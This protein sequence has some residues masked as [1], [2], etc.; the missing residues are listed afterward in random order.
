MQGIRGIELER[1]RGEQQDQ[2]TATYVERLLE[3]LESDPHLLDN[4]FDKLPAELSFVLRQLPNDRE[5]LRPFLGSVAPLMLKEEKYGSPLNDGDKIDLFLDVMGKPEC[6]EWI[7]RAIL[8][9]DPDETDDSNAPA[10]LEKTRNGMHALEEHEFEEAHQ[11][12]TEALEESDKITP[13]SLWSFAIMR[14]LVAACAGTGRLEEAE[15]LAT[16][17]IAA[18]ETRLGK[19]HPDLSYP[20]S[21]LAHVRE[22]Q[23]RSEEAETLH[24]HAVQIVERSKGLDHQDLIPSLD[25]MAYFYS[26]RDDWN[27]AGEL[28]RRILTIHESNPEAKE[29]DREEYLEA[30]LEIDLRRKEF[31][32]AEV[33]AKR[34]LEL[35]K[36]TGLADTPQS[37]V[38]MGLL[39]ACLLARGKTAESEVVFE[40][41]V[42]LLAE[43]PLED[44][45]KVAFVFECYVEQLVESG[46]EDK[47]DECEWLSRRMVYR[48]MEFSSHGCD[49][50]ARTIPVI[51]S[52]DVVYRLCTP[53]NKSSDDCGFMTESD[54]DVSAHIHARLVRELQDYFA[55]LDFLRVL[56]DIDEL[57]DD[58]VTR[59][60]PQFLR[61]GIEL[62]FAF[63]TFADS[64]GFL[65]VLRKVHNIEEVS[66]NE[67]ID[68]F[69]DALTE[70]QAFKDS[71]IAEFVRSAYIGFLEQHNENDKAAELRN[72]E[73]E[74]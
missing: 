37:G 65:D 10:W 15:P 1:D 5:M 36:N 43:S 35:R 12:L 20:Y 63:R 44:N 54:D 38:I 26:R 6:F 60:G 17:W 42:E 53:D 51:I 48:N 19:W 4:W 7:V 9:K 31:A 28:F 33:Q 13:D 74:S 68:K 2:E 39:A 27:R 59:I 24:Q 61:D 55:D 46:A 67:G 3:R 64:A 30:L 29:E 14:A 8:G 11:L 72:R 52:A 16:R 50:Y 40:R 57:Q 62:D 21:I 56:T 73:L 34:I 45:E 69:E 22:L 18:G 58:F 66:V 32:G 70:A 25:S 49:I 23:D 71:D 41:A 47:A